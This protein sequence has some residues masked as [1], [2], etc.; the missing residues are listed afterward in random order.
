MR[1]A[2]IGQPV[3]HS[4]S[5]PMHRAALLFFGLEGSYEL[6]ELAPDN[7]LKG[8]ES[9]CKEGF[10]GFNATIPHKERLF[11]LFGENASWQAKMLSAANTVR[12]DSSSRLHLHNTDMGGFLQ[13]LANLQRDENQAEMKPTTSIGQMKGNAIV[14][15]AG[16]AARACV[17]GLALSSYSTIFV[18]SRQIE[19]SSELCKSLQVALS[20]TVPGL[21]P[22]LEAMSFDDIAKREFSPIDIIVNC[23]P[24]GLSKND[25]LPTWFEELL[26]KT[27]IQ[28][29]FMDTVYRRD[30]RET[31]LQ[32][33]AMRKGLKTAD[34]LSMLV[35]QAVLAFAF[36]T[37]RRPPSELMMAAARAEASSYQTAT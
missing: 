19:S 37:G 1:F 17:A 4:L 11:D 31:L 36:W 28:S 6:L 9:A 33:E 12:I 7:L 30:L 13:A 10:S 25:S 2:L 3:K 22:R 5:P 15:G 18:L 29:V 32:K 14:L 21:E 8:V 35:E 23:T 20:D 24:L 27:A 34:G 26:Q 16:G